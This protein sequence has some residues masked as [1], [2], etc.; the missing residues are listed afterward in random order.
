MEDIGTGNSMM[1]PREG[2]DD[3]CCPLIRVVPE[4][5]SDTGNGEMIT[6]AK[7]AQKAEGDATHEV[8]PLPNAK[9]HR[10]N[11]KSRPESVTTRQMKM[12]TLKR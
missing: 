5:D 2:K 6:A 4:L 10:N 8:K 7:T 12:A 3:P 1:Y 9:D 11:S